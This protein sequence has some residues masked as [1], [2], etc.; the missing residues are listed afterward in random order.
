MELRAFSLRILKML[1]AKFYHQ[2]IKIP[3]ASKISNAKILNQVLFFYSKWSLFLFLSYFSLLS[4]L[5]S[6]TFLFS[7]SRSFCFSLFHGL[8]S[9]PPRF[10]DWE[11]KSPNITG[12]EIHFTFKVLPSI[13]R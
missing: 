7:L 12:H 13:W 2:H 8:S 4:S 3:T 6:P 9:S 5:S 10:V 11:L 1:K